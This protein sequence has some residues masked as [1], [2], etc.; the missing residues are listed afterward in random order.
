[1]L[2]TLVTTIAGREDGGTLSQDIVTVV[3]GTAGSAGAWTDIVVRPGIAGET[4]D[5]VCQNHAN[6]G[7]SIT[8]AA[9][10][11]GNYGDGLTLDAVV[12]GGVFTSIKSTSSQGQNYAANDTLHSSKTVADVGG[13]GSG[14]IFRLD[15]QDLTLSEVTNISLTGGPYAVSDVLSVD[16]GDAGGTGSGFQYTVT[17]VGFIR[18][19]TISDGGFGYNPTQTLIPRVPGNNRRYKW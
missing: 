17:K 9:G 4:A 15:Q 14:V 16:P 7:A 12:E 10:A 13:A 11:A 1:M 6:M 5:Y 2:P 3:N 19:V 18:D 8:I